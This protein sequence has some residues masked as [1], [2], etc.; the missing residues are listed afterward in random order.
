MSKPEM[1]P[2]P[3]CGEMPE[4]HER[5]DGDGTLYGW[6]IDCGNPS[7]PCLPSALEKTYDETVKAWN[8]RSGK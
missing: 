8:T 6:T 7:C 5:R 2:C 3:F 4:I 1:L